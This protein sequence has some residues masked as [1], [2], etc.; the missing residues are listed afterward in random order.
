MLGA[1]VPAHAEEMLKISLSEFEDKVRGAMAGQMAGVTF[2][3]PTEFKWRGEIVDAE[4]QWTPE[5]IKD[6]LDQDDVYVEMTFIEVMDKYGL[7][8]TIDQFGEAFRDSRYEVWH[9]NAAGRRHLFHGRTGG[10][11]G[12]PKNNIHVNDIDFQIE[13]DFIGILSPGMP[14]SAI[15]LCDRVGHLMSYGDGF[16]GGVFVAGMYTR[17]FFE[18][19]AAKV[20]QAGVDCLPK[21][22]GYRACI[23]DVI[24][25]HKK[26]PDD[27]K[28]C[29]RQ[30]N[31][32]WDKNESC[33]EGA[34]EPFNVSALINGAYIA[35]GMLYGEGDF[36]KTIEISLRC[37]QDSD[38]NPSSAAGVLGAMYG[39]KA[40]DNRYG[41]GS[42]ERNW[43]G[44]LPTFADEDFFYTKYSFNRFVDSAI[45]LTKEAV[46]RSGGEVR[47]DM[48]IIP[49]RDPVPPKLE[50]WSMGVPIETI[51]HDDS[52][53]K[54]KGE[55]EV[56]PKRSYYSPA[57]R[58]SYEGGNEAT[59]EFNGTA[60]AI[61]GMLQQRYGG[62]V[63]I[64]L[65][66]EIVAR[67]DAY[68]PKDTTDKDL[69]HTYGLE[70][71]PH[72]VRIVTLDE[73]HPK[74]KGSWIRIEYAKVYREE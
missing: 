39:Y 26:Y 62:M 37:G 30:I 68:I 47:D 59:L 51:N 8:A 3:D 7:D 5:M 21:G 55:W 52:A 67:V 34:L 29:W 4:L 36:S 22:S 40:L 2:G 35:I 41:N 12:H 14:L 72:T 13:S 18:K 58:I 56:R 27:W 43:I 64:Y 46:K 38:C 74:A 57:S 49:K 10:M 20:L 60:V 17:A 71:G 32:R 73:R 44:Y 1:V 65:D 45:K 66:D 48:L 24:A 19:D 23:E 69:W 42:S 53:W 15:E 54:W 11:S 33:P 25:T 31:A 50:Q 16:Y 28:E 63:D 61:A 6:A 70:D 9:T